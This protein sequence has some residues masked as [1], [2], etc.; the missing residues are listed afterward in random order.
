MEST[1]NIWYW[2]LRK[3]NLFKNENGKTKI[4]ILYLRKELKT[5]KGRNK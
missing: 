3:E 4:Q 2:K 1:Q 5:K